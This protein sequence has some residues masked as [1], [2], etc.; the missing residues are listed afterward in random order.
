MDISQIPQLENAYFLA[1][2]ALLFAKAAAN[3]LSIPS[4]IFKNRDANITSGEWEALAT[5]VRKMI[6]LQVGLEMF[7]LCIASAVATHIFLGL[8]AIYVV[9]DAAS[10]HKLMREYPCA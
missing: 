3:Y 1:L 5:R 9:A 10:I 6:A 8:F 2:A 4:V 7:A